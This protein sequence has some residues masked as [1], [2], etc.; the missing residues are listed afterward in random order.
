M[1]IKI[2]ESAADEHARVTLD[3]HSVDRI[4]GST[5]RLKALVNGTICGKPGHARPNK[6]VDRCKIAPE[7]NPFAHDGVF[8]ES[9]KGPDG[10]RITATLVNHDCYVGVWTGS[11]GN[12]VS[13]RTSKVREITVKIAT[14]NIRRTAIKNESWAIVDMERVRNTGGIEHERDRSGRRL[15]IDVGPVLGGGGP[16]L[17][18]PQVGS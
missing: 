5:T 18:R 10:P 4:V 16:P 12:D 13:D 7:H 15:R 1:K 14:V 8:N 2:G 17:P 11:I 3:H 6:A 9:I